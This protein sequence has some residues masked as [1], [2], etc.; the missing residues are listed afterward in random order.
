MLLT[1]AASAPSE[2]GWV[3]EVKWDGMR[4]QALLDRGRLTVRSRRG[5]DCTAQFPELADAP[6][7]ATATHTLLLDGALVCFNQ[8]GRPDFARLRAR[9]ARSG[10]GARAHAAR[11]P[12]T[13]IVFDVLHADGHAVRRLPYGQR[14][15]LLSE[16]Q[17]TG[18]RWQTPEAFDAH[19]DLIAATRAHDLEGVVAKRLDAADQPGRRSP[20]W[21][22]IKN[23]RTERLV[24]VGWQPGLGE[25]DSLLLARPDPHTGKLRPAGRVPLR[26]AERDR[27]TAR[28]ALA[29]LERPRR[30]RGRL[31]MLEPALEIDV[32]HHGG[33]DGPVRDP[34]A[35]TIRPRSTARSRQAASSSP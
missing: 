19:A 9:L 6:P 29:Q 13:L 7:T 26:I 30:A 16:L 14:R 20:T 8:Q 15:K 12:V 5:R 2:D 33:T 21:R 3:L 28:R 23:T 35:R 27:A 10:A 31:R 32:S 4:A 24:I 17:L 22:K 11:N 34:H 18:A 1:P 25:P